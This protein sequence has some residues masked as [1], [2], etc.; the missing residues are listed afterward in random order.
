MDNRWHS[1]SKK[2]NR[3]QFGLQTDKFCAFR[4]M[5]HNF[6]SLRRVSWQ[7]RYPKPIDQFPM[8]NLWWLPPCLR[9]LALVFERWSI[10]AS[11]GKSRSLAALLQHPMV[12]FYRHLCHHFIFSKIIAA[13]K[14]YIRSTLDNRW[15]SASNKKFVSSFYF[16]KN[17][18]CSK[19]LHSLYIG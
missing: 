11:T 10:H 2:K 18:S 8:I 12:T 9:A 13:P 1:A 17:H 19:I 6:G 15:H 5:D 4:V 16:F 7:R 14:F 3:A